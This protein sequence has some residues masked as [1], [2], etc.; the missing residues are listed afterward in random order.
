MKTNEIINKADAWFACRVRLVLKCPDHIAKIK[1][2]C[3]KIIDE[4]TIELTSHGYNPEHH[5]IGD[6]NYGYHPEN[7]ESIE[8][9]REALP[10]EMGAIVRKK[11]DGEKNEK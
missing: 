2:D 7:V 9:V 8:Y 3:K 5:S 4:H 10:E 6:D 11:K 1:G